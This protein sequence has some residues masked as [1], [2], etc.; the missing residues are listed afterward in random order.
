MTEV[1][2]DA[3]QPLATTPFKNE[4]RHLRQPK[5][6]G[7]FANYRGTLR[8]LPKMIDVYIT[9]INIT[10]RG[11]G[12]TEPWDTTRY[13]TSAAFAPNDPRVKNNPDF[14][15]YEAVCKR[16]QHVQYGHEDLDVYKD[17]REPPN[18]GNPTPTKKSYFKSSSNKMDVDDDDE[19]N[20]FSRPC[21]CK[22]AIRPRDQ[23]VITASAVSK[24]DYSVT[25]QVTGW[26]PYVDVYKPMAHGV[27][28]DN[29]KPELLEE[30]L[31]N[32][33]CPDK[34]HPLALVYDV[35]LTW[36]YKCFG[37]IGDKKNP[38]KRRKF[39]VWRCYLNTAVQSYKYKLFDL[40]KEANPEEPFERYD[41]EEVTT[42]AQ[43]NID[44]RKGT[45]HLAP[46]T[47]V[48]VLD[49]TESMV[50][51]TDTMIEI[52]V[53]MKDIIKPPPDAKC[54]QSPTAPLT[55]AS[56]DIEVTRPV[57]SKN[58][59]RDPKDALSFLEKDPLTMEGTDGRPI[60]HSG[61]ARADEPNDTTV[62]M[63][64]NLFKTGNFDAVC[65]NATPLEN[66][67]FVPEAH[68]YQV[69]KEG[70][71]YYMTD[72]N[73]QQVEDTYCQRFLPQPWVNKTIGARRNPYEYY[74]DDTIEDAEKT[75]KDTVDKLL[76]S[77][78]PK[79]GMAALEDASDKM[80]FELLPKFEACAKELLALD[81][82]QSDALVE[83]FKTLEL[84]Y[85]Q[86][87][88]CM[89]H[90]GF[91]PE[92]EITDNPVLVQI[93]ERD[94]KRLAA[95]AHK[96]HQSYR[97]CWT[98]LYEAKVINFK[99]ER[100]NTFTTIMLTEHE[101][102]QRLFQPARTNKVLR[103]Q[104]NI[105]KYNFIY[106][107]MLKQERGVD[108][109]RYAIPHLH[110]LSNVLDKDEEENYIL[111]HVYSR[112]IDIHMAW[113]DLLVSVHP[114]LI[115]AHN[116]QGYDN[117]M[118]FTRCN[119]LTKD[120]QTV[121][122][123]NSTPIDK[124]LS[125]PYFPGSFFQDN[126]KGYKEYLPKCP[127][128]KT[129]YRFV[130]RRLFEPAMFKRKAS[131]S[132]QAGVI[133]RYYMDVNG[134]SET[135]THLAFKSLKPK[136]QSWALNALAN[137]ELKDNKMD[138][139]IPRMNACNRERYFWPIIAYCDYD[140]VLPIALVEQTG[141]TVYNATFGQI[142]HCS[143]DRICKYGMSS[144]V[145]MVFLMEAYARG[146][147][148]EKHV[149]ITPQWL[150]GAKVWDG[151]PQ[152]IPC[153]TT[154]LDFASLYPSEIISNNL[155]MTTVMRVL[156]RQMEP[157]DFKDWRN[158]AWCQQKLREWDVI[159]QELYGK[160]FVPDEFNAND[161]DRE[162]FKFFYPMSSA[163]S[164]RVNQNYDD[165][166]SPS[167]EGKVMS[168]EEKQKA[169]VTYSTNKKK[170]KKQK[171]K[172]TKLKE[173]M[174][175]YANDYVI[176]VFDFIINRP[177]FYD[178]VEHRGIED[179]G[180]VTPQVCETLLALR[181][182]YKKVMSDAEEAAEKGD[183]DAA[184]TAVNANFQQNAAKI[185]CNTVY[186]WVSMK[187][188]KLKFTGPG[189]G[190]TLFGRRH[191]K[192]C[193]NNMQT[194]WCPNEKDYNFMKEC[195]DWTKAN[196]HKL[197]YNM[198]DYA[199]KLL[200]KPF[201]A[202]PEDGDQTKWTNWPYKRPQNERELDE[203]LKRTNSAWGL[204]VTYGDTDSIMVALWLCLIYELNEHGIWE[205]EMSVRER[206]INLS[207]NQSLYLQALFAKFKHKRLKITWEKVIEPF[208]QFN[209]QKV[210][211]GFQWNL[212]DK[213][214]KIKRLPKPVL[215]SME[216]RDMSEFLLDI[217]YR[218]MYYLSVDRSGI[219]AIPYVQRRLYVLA[220]TGGLPS[221]PGLLSM[222][223]KTKG[224]TKPNYELSNAGEHVTAN[225]R[226][227]DSPKYK[228]G[229]YARGDRVPFVIVHTTN[230]KKQVKECSITLRE[231]EFMVSDA[232]K[233][234]TFTSIDDLKF[235]RHP[236]RLDIDG[237]IKAVQNAM[238]FFFET[239]AASESEADRKKLNQSNDILSPIVCLSDGRV[240]KRRFYDIEHLC[241]AARAIFVGKMSLT[242]K[243]SLAL[244]LSSPQAETN[245]KKR[246]HEDASKSAPAPKRHAGKPTVH[247]DIR[248]FFQRKK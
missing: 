89:E 179:A 12:T 138:I 73:G 20:D 7:G 70:Q 84:A 214:G 49:W 67:R 45:I 237:V 182:S 50:Y 178:G 88:K 196:V 122:S 77:K 241:D 165:S 10:S 131:E 1:V 121:Q 217:L 53:Q 25:L 222:C 161:E 195:Y 215:K 153:I 209:K 4:I 134:Y 59:R 117:P 168:S 157:V 109:I 248:T 167:N 15:R 107:P 247:T 193:A 216:K 135:D 183:K 234:G 210:Y 228:G 136:R 146:F 61:F 202:R 37:F 68:G 86:A 118:L 162:D 133:E 36:G 208:V 105:R 164:V 24:Q 155:C 148:M 44:A 221:A 94:K 186:G 170:T 206:V 95:A 201:P 231:I 111:T 22:L 205:M 149:P 197:P 185:F 244:P 2:A 219:R 198:K 128:P 112:E 87:G 9:D 130:N 102:Q 154:T 51:F 207:V 56:M 38:Y 233:A 199:E 158:T 223:T 125:S 91:N 160:P 224:L 48:R 200:A 159:R 119:Y 16:L 152:I 127:N 187:T 52:N 184:V 238:S 229:E 104:K 99:P 101:Y 46:C 55:A 47:W 3:P 213:T 108:Q 116:C 14:Y 74:A 212:D 69:L 115:Y 225:W 93:C 114:D 239:A 124:R 145:T 27:C 78:P 62:C 226:L 71:K 120:V 235:D 240:V 58:Y 190:T 42:D 82:D 191:I 211:G 72:R 230:S 81:N 60:L 177:E 18:P 110:N 30:E 189:I 66:T 103:N 175:K 76:F 140:T 79:D 203:M 80:H 96:M 220:R 132:A 21:E 150:V 97:A 142:A 90:F 218:C 227:R 75:L 32:L 35:K 174:E 39:P 156:D 123:S 166:Y 163:V 41:H 34:E 144:A 98:K 31:R 33:L 13:L 242:P 243:P 151:F 236:L 11:T 43:L 17:N 180:G 8:C 139:G 92:R 64:V 29:Y 54:W 141:L 194:R 192:D 6:M 232:I 169:S 181:Q 19:P 100:D 188:S 63:S 245:D 126:G 143:I 5:Q 28:A 173:K 113:R 26:R 172:K 83:K 176:P 65:K 171:E 147:I 204:H 129:P 23:L 57:T 85:T 40:L 106:D 246:P 137:D